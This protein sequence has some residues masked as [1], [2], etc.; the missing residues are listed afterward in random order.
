MRALLERCEGQ[1]SCYVC[2]TPM[3]PTIRCRAL[4]LIADVLLDSAH[5]ARD[6]DETVHV[7]E[8]A[9]SRAKASGCPGGGE[10][11]VL[12]DTAAVGVTAPAEQMAPALGLDEAAMP[13][14]APS[15][16]GDERDAEQ[17]L[18]LSAGGSVSSELHQRDD[19][20]EAEFSEALVKRVKAAIESGDQNLLFAVDDHGSTLL[21]GAAVCGLVDSV[22]QLIK[23]GGK[24]L[25]FATDKNGWSAL[26]C[27]SFNVVWRRRGC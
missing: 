9:E 2:T 3:V 15:A 27:A 13:H 1:V 18:P 20:G 6:S 4:E 24:K 7:G 17:S 8:V 11:S 25:L 12:L 23:A 19:S 14:G 16:R 22:Q 26:Y 10:E 5:E 21:H